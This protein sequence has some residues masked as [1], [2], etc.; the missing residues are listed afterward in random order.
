MY[1]KGNWKRYKEKVIIME[2]GGACHLNKR[3]IH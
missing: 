1:S 3:M 2:G